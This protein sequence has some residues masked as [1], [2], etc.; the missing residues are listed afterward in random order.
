M[1]EWTILQGQD[2]PG[3]GK[4]VEIKWFEERAASQEITRPLT[5]ITPDTTDSCLFLRAASVT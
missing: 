1:W 5:G 3:A 2:D 4:G